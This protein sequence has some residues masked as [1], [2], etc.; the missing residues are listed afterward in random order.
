MKTIFKGMV[1]LLA[2]ASFVACS[3]D[4]SFDE[5]AQKQA[6]EAKKQAELDQKYATYDAEFVK[7]FGTI[8]K[9]P[10]DLLRDILRV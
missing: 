4:V 8:A 3:K 7:A 1:L 2:G 6:E 5:N 10:S 9:G